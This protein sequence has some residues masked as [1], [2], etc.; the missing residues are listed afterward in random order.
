MSVQCHYKYNNELHH[1][2]KGEYKKTDD[3]TLHSLASLMLSKCHIFSI[4]IYHFFAQSFAYSL[5][6]FHT[7]LSALIFNWR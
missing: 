5:L 4:E 2:R 6:V 3:E 7:L 1:L